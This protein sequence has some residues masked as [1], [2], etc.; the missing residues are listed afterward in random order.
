MFSEEFFPTSSDVSA[1]MRARISK[2]AQYFL[3]PNAGKGNLAEAIRGERGYDRKKVDCIEISS[4]LCAILQDKDF[5]VVGT[6][7][8]EYDG[9]CYYDAIVMNPP[10]S[11]GDVHLLKAW[12][13]LHDGEI[14]CLLNEETIKNPHTKNR[15]RLAAIIEQHGDIEYLGDCFSTA[16]RKTGVRVAMVYLKKEAEDDR[17]DLWANDSQERNITDDIQAGNIPA[18]MDSLGNM[19]H[20]YDIVETGFHLKNAANLSNKVGPP[21]INLYC[22]AV[23]LSMH[24][25]HFCENANSRRS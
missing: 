18:V 12:D 21:L 5:S 20:Y 11:N 24:R 17:V 8:L 7:W 9:V 14:V 25:F 6:D 3:E 16:E 1:K 2:N 4:E 13:F 10:F 15:K 19:Q 23:F 22:Y